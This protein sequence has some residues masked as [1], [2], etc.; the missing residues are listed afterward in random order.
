ML[1][2]DSLTYKDLDGIWAHTARTE[3]EKNACAQT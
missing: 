1:I 2:N 3:L